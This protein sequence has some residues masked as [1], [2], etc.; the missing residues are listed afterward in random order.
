MRPL[1]T[2]LATQLMWRVVVASSDSLLPS[3]VLHWRYHAHR[4]AALIVWRLQRQTPSK[5]LGLSVTCNVVGEGY[6]GLAHNPR[7]K[8]AAP[9]PWVATGAGLLSNKLWHN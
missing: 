4:G 2:T 9:V 3:R 1:Y 6:C 5:A 8:A 7:T